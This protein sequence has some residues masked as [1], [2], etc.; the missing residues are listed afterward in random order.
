MEATMS[1]DEA[2]EVRRVAQEAYGAESKHEDFAVLDDE[3]PDK[4]IDYDG[5]VTGYWVKARVW[6]PADWVK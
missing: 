4:I 1:N 3:D 5:K 2:V 6:V